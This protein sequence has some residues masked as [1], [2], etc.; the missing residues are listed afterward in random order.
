[1]KR[2]SAVVL[3]PDESLLRVVRDRAPANEFELKLELPVSPDHLTENQLKQIGLCKPRLIL[4]DLEA[5]PDVGCRLT[6]HLSEEHPEARIFAIA[7]DPSPQFLVEI[8]RSGAS[9]FLE[10]PVNDV[11]L[12]EALA[13]MRRRAG[14]SEW[15]EEPEGRVLGFFSPKGGAG[16]TTVATNLAVQL[17]RRTG[18]RILL[19]DMD[20][21]LGEIAIFLGLEYR[22]SVMDLVS[23]M[24]RLDDDLL[25]TLL[26]HHDS[27]LD[28]LPAPYRPRREEH[29]TGEQ[30]RRVV[31]FLRGRY[32]YILLDVSNS[33]TTQG[34]AALGTVD[35][36]F[37]V[38]QV[39]VPSLRNIQRCRE[40][41]DEVGR[42]E[43]TLHLIVNRYDPKRQISLDEVEESLGLPVYWALSND[44]DSVVYSINTGEV[45]VMNVPCALSREIEGLMEKI[46]GVEKEARSSAKRGFLTRISDFFR[47]RGRRGRRI[48]RPRMKAPPAGQEASLTPAPHSATRGEGL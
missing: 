34:F 11:D 7:A 36:L 23:N 47:R 24:H 35:D 29:L 40:I 46:T 5:N 1:M 32:D 9:E 10:K 33:L 17:R 8:M 3:S 42:D 27:G 18:K 26:E 21:E 4:L 16:V 43:S 25:P 39:D 2:L 48:S 31:R 37:A 41:L 6:A 44:Y 14:P 28:V 20:L 19:V 15:A 22:Y 38:S 12:D 13:R 30:I 45:M